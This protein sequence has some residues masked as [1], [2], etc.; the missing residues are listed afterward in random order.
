MKKVGIIIGA[1]LILVLG[2]GLFFYFKIW[3]GLK[4]AIGPR[5][6]ITTLPAPNPVEG[7]PITSR[8]PEFPTGKPVPFPLVLPEGFQIEIIAELP[9]AVRDLEFDKNNPNILYASIP[10]KGSIVSIDISKPL[11]FSEVI[12][13]L[14]IPH[15]LAIDSQNPN[16]LYIAEGNQIIRHDLSRG[17]TKKIIDIPLDGGHTTRSLGFGADGKLYVSIG[18]TCNVCNEPDERYAAISRLNPDGS[19]FEV[20]AKGLRNSVFFTFHPETKKILAGDMGRDYLGDDLPPEE[21]NIIDPLLNPGKN[22]GWPV[23]YGNK[24]FDTKFDSGK[25]PN[26]CQTTEPPVIEMPAHSAPLGLWF[27]TGD[28]FGGDFKNNLFISYHGSWNRSVPTGYKVVRV[29]FDKDGEP[30]EIQDFLTGFLADGGAYGRPVDVIQ[31]PNGELYL[32][33]DKANVIY[34]II[35]N[36]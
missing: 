32:S 21:V 24:I 5:A 19:A 8:K 10:Q 29:P 23:C 9:G 28:L 6:K 2:G 18:S 4:P 16:F 7:L 17:E 1:F 30:L 3:P 34:R 31:G 25:T 13:G 14:N 15:G 20:F 33:D 26:Y 27:Y 22:Y 12:S 36:S 11:S 35:K